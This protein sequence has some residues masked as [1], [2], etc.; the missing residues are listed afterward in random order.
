MSDENKQ[1]YSAKAKKSAKYILYITLLMYPINALLAYPRIMLNPMGESCKY[2]EKGQ[3][4]DI[5]L[6]SDPCVLT[7]TFYGFIFIMPLYFTLIFSSPF[8]IRFL[9]YL[10]RIK[11]PSNKG[12]HKK[13][14]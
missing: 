5:I 2:V 8:I 4:Y 11:V 6:D 10:Y 7:D 1:K 3:P 14:K 9:Y 12:R 13:G